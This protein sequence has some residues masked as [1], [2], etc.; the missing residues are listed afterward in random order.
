MM[1]VINKQKKKKK[2]IH[3]IIQKSLNFSIF[4]VKLKNSNKI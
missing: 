3:N 4:N 2:Y 1:V